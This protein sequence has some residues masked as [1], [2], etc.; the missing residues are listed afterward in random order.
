MAEYDPAT[1]DLALTR[2][3]MAA[4]A[5]AILGRGTVDYVRDRCVSALIKRNEK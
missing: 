3:S 1:L 4:A 2:A 5:R